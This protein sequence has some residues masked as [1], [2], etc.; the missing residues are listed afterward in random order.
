MSLASALWRP[1]THDHGISATTESLLH[2]YLQS[3]QPQTNVGRCNIHLSLHRTNAA[4]SSTTHPSFVVCIVKHAYGGW[5]VV[6]RDVPLPACASGPWLAEWLK[7]KSIP[8]YEAY[9]REQFCFSVYAIAHL[10]DNGRPSKIIRG[11]N[12]RLQFGTIR[13]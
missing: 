5:W 3:A 9:P 1:R 13:S 6:L 11:H 7:Y 10:H 12:D 4:C 2:E 8:L